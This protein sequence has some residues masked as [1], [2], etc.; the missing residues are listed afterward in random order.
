[1][2][3][4]R[5]R[6]RGEESG[7]TRSTPKASLRTVASDEARER[8]L[9]AC[10]REPILTTSTDGRIMG[11][12][13]AAMALFGDAARLYGRPIEELVPFVTAQAES[14]ADQTIWQ[15]QVDDIT[16]RSIDVEVSRSELAEGHLPASVVYVIHDISRHAALNRL[17]EQLLFDIAHELRAPLTVLD[18]A[19]EILA[20][21]HQ[22]LSTGDFERLIRSARRTAARLGILME[23]LL[24]AGSIQAGR[25]RVRAR[26]VDL[27]VV[28]DEALEVVDAAIEARGQRVERDL[29]SEG[30]RALADQRFIRQV[31]A[32]LLSNASKYSPQGGVIELRGERTGEYVTLAVQDRGPGISSE[33]RA[34]L[35]ERFYRVRP[36]NQERGVGLGLAIAKGIVEAHGGS[37]GVDSE[38]NVGTL[39]WFTLP[40]APRSR[41][42]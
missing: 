33:Q 13:E 20:T 35:F 25:F 6:R 12:N 19:L 1:M 8:A 42:G 3:N 41:R 14:A 40:A 34:G 36:G 9:F 22:D 23:D 30:L 21:E 10:L 2:L 11:F 29:P 15:G 27:S 16:G 31:L 26:P 5:R 38:V 28:V 17:R 37:I 39:V 24:S 32:N 4:T 7:R 18:N